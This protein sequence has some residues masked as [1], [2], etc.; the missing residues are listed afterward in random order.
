MLGIRFLLAGVALLGTVDLVFAFRPGW[1]I[2]LM[3]VGVLLVG[4]AWIALAVLGWRSALAATAAVALSYV[5][6]FAAAPV[7]SNLSWRMLVWTHRG[8]LAEAVRILEPVESTTWNW[9][10]D[11]RCEGLA[12]LSPSDCTALQAQLREFGAFNAWKEGPATGFTTHAWIN[13]RRG[14][15]YCPRDQADACAAP[16][17]DHLTG[18]WYLWSM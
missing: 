17:R 18:E 11:P 13:V 5:L 3:L 1:S 9:R 7:L 8:A 14:I 10:P 12:A 2:L 15:L 16:H 4:Y 6:L